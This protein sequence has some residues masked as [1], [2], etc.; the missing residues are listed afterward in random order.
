MLHVTYLLVDFLYDGGFMLRSKG[1]NGLI[2]LCH[3]I[4]VVLFY[5]VVINYYQRCV[6]LYNKYK[7][8]LTISSWVV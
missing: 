1:G 3:D 8:Y 7:Y 6:T 2:Y 5:V 4:I